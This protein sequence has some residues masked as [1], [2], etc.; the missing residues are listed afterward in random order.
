MMSFQSLT[1]LRKECEISGNATWIQQGEKIKMVIP[2]ST[3]GEILHLFP[4]SLTS[5]ALQVTSP[6]TS[7]MSRGRGVLTSATST[8]GIFQPL[9]HGVTPPLYFAWQ[10]TGE[11][12]NVILVFSFQ[13]DEIYRSS[14]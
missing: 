5:P 6:I 7:A 8:A 9:R 11:E 4:V 1:F 2:I 12:G 10:N 14:L 3:Q 13:K